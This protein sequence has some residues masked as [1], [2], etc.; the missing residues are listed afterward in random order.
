[1]HVRVHGVHVARTA[2]PVAP[3]RLAISYSSPF[4]TAFIL[5]QAKSNAGGAKSKTVNASDWLVWRQ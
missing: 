5:L 2:V 4:P 1:M 3:R